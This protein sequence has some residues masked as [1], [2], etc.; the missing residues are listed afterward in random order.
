MDMLSRRTGIDYDESGEGASAP[1]SALI[2]Q[3]RGFVRRQY[4]IFLIVPAVAIAIGLLFL[5]VTS[6]QYTAT[7]TLLI[8]SSSLRVLQNQLQ[9]QGDIPL[10]TLQVGSQVEV[11]ASRKIAL[12]VIRDLKL[13]EDPEFVGT[14]SGVSTPISQANP[15]TSPKDDKEMRALEAFLARRSISRM[16]RTYA[17]NISFTSHSPVAAAKIANAIA[18]AYIDDQLGAKYQT[19][20]RASA[21]LQD[22][23]NELKAKVTSA[24]E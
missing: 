15:D 4:Q 3:L 8:D 9:P 7:A 24:V 11:L 20:S 17:L 6:A 18:D 16:E 19:I 1:M 14:G 12:A 21:W 2:E 23:I 13:A 5:L 10:D 22:R